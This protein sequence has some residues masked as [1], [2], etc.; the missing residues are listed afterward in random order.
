MARLARFARLA[1]TMRQLTFGRREVDVEF[2]VDVGV[3]VDGI[4]WV[5]GRVE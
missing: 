2:D 4:R 5:I 1:V 3:E